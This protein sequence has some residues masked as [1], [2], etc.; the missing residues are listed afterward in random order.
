M[1]RTFFIFL[2]LGI[3][4]LFVFSI[5][6]GH[7]GKKLFDVGYYYVVDTKLVHLVTNLV[8]TTVHKTGD[9]AGNVVDD[10][11]E[12]VEQHEQQ[13]QQYEQPQE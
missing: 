5:P 2:L 8:S 7:Q 12:N 6:V 3:A 9:T 13:Q 10:V 1:L 11:V 4:W